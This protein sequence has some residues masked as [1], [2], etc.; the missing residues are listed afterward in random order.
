MNVLYKNSK[1]QFY[2]GFWRKSKDIKK[3]DINK[4]LFPYPLKKKK[5][6]KNKKFLSKLKILQNILLKKN[7]FTLYKNYKICVYTNKKVGKKIFT[8]FNVHWD[9]TLLYYITNYNIKPSKNFI[10]FILNIKTLNKKIYI[11]K[12]YKYPNF[13]I[14]GTIFKRYNI[15]Y[16]KINYNQLRILDSLYIDGSNNNYIYKK[17]KCIQNIQDY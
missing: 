1:L 12:A 5:K 17:K 11:D 7:K 14:K 16:L 9:E 2:E 6:L 4:K 10:D 8:L 13:K 15:K 3:Y